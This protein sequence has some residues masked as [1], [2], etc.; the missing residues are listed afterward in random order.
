MSGFEP[1]PA[2]GLDDVSPTAQSAALKRVL[3]ARHA[4]DCI[5]HSAAKSEFVFVVLAE[6]G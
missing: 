4:G 1:G 6:A 3:A 5:A 2:L